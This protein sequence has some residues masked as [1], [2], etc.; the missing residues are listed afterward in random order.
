MPELSP[1]AVATLA[2]LDERPMHP[3]EMY[4]LMRQR[5]ED[6]LVK[7]SVGALYNTVD[8]L[9]QAGL[10]RAVGTSQV[11]N[12]PER[13]TYELG[14]AGRHTL[15]DR[16]AHLIRHPGRDLSPIALAVNEIHN[17]EEAEALQALVDGVASIDAELAEIE[18]LS[19]TACA[20][21]VPEIYSLAASYARAV[22]TAERD[23]LA[24]L[25]TRIRSK[26]LT[27]P[28]RP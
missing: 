22:R 1:L 6:R 9:A 15:L 7:V 23:W 12:R 17:L 21:A 28:S 8:R 27:W 10:V 26:D 20:E 3:Y 24:G 11:G 2:L 25:I 14:P 16:I 19:D 13:T 4:Q 5:H 18:L